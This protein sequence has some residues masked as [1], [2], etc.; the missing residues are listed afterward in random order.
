MPVLDSVVD[1]DMEVVL[2]VEILGSKPDW[3]RR[4][5]VAQTGETEG[6]M[7]F[8]AHTRLSFQRRGTK[9]GE[10]REEKKSMIRQSMKGKKGIKA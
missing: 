6:C 1:A 10:K 7:D 3:K 5:E 8:L 9:G 4:P 2:P